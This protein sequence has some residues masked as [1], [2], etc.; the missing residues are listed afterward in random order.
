M[1]AAINTAAKK[2]TTVKLVA[3]FPPFD[4]V[5]TGQVVGAEATDVEIDG[6]VQANIDNGLLIKCS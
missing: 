5:P 6:W 1:A 2:P 4:I 3:K